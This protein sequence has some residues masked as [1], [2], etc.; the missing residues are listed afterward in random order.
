[1]RKF[2]RTSEVGDQ[3]ALLRTTDSRSFVEGPTMINFDI[4]VSSFGP[5]QDMDM[6]WR[7]R[8]SALSSQ[9]WSSSRTRWT[10]TFDSDGATNV[11]SSLKKW[12]CFPCLRACSND[13]G[14]PIPSFTIR[15]TP[16]YTPYPPVI[17]SGVFLQMAPS[18]TRR[19][20]AFPDRMKFPN[21]LPRITVKARCN[22]NLKNFP[23]DVQ[24]CKFFIGSCKPSEHEIRFDF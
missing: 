18:G 4:L 9:I 20:T 16:I 22:M 1:M 6:V 24:I 7:R 5:I 21:L 17:V 15:N 3:S 23:V 14:D 11:C 8:E 12:E 2:D 13:C 10:V 19:G